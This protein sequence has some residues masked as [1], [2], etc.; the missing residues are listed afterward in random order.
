MPIYVGLFTRL[1]GA[2]VFACTGSW[3]SISRMRFRSPVSWTFHFSMRARI[4]A[5]DVVAAEAPAISWPDESSGKLLKSALKTMC[6]I[7]MELM[8][9]EPGVQLHEFFAQFVKLS[10]GQHG[11]ACLWT[12]PRWKGQASGSLRETLALT[13]SAGGRG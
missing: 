3:C 7:S 2:L 8:A 13:L 4:S 10:I 9:P 1:R 6:S 5:F 11:H 12:S